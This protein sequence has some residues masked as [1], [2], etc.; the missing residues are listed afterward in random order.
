MKYVIDHKKNQD[1][2]EE[3]M[4]TDQYGNYYWCVKVTDDVSLDGEIYVMA[5]EVVVTDSG[6][7]E[8]RRVGV[9]NR[10][11]LTLAPGK[12]LAVYSASL[13]DGHAVAVEHW[14]EEIES[15]PYAPGGVYT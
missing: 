12:W 1:E 3:T 9:K 7:L 8:C 4:G 2:R 11:N 5:D 14:A 10:V 6:A 15:E 13:V